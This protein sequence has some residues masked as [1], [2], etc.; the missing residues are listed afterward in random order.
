MT[1]PTCDRECPERPGCWM[2]IK[3]C[4]EKCPKNKD[5]KVRRDKKC[6]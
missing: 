5:C 6:S 4:K 1:P 3:Y 2:Y